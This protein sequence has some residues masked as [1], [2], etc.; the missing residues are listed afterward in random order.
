MMRR[1]SEPQ[2]RAQFTVAEL[3]AR[4]GDPAPGAGRRRRR[5][6]DDSDD[7]AADT[8]GVRGAAQPVME[9]NWTASAAESTQPRLTGTNAGDPSGAAPAHAAAQDN[10]A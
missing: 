10:T 6:D 3:L 2:E 5:A 7:G 8:A 9:R 4:Y 1:S